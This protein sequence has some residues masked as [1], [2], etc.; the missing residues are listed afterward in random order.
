MP[1][2]RAPHTEIPKIPVPAKFQKE[3]PATLLVLI[4]LSAL[5]IGYYAELLRNP[6]AQQAFSGLIAKI[7]P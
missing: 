5:L 3:T 2:F 7:A 1:S 4:G 6:W